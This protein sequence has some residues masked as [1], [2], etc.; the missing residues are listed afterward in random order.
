M[1]QNPSVRSILLTLASVAF[2]AL[3]TTPA[4]K[5]ES[6]TV[7]YGEFHPYSFTNAAGEAEGFAVDVV[8]NV[9]KSAG[10]EAEFVYSV[11]PA[12]TLEMLEAGEADLTTFL[13]TTPD[14][15]ERALA[16]RHIG[17]FELAA[18]TLRGSDASEN[19]DLAG[20]RV[21]VVKGS[22]A[23]TA[24]K[25]IPFVEIVEYQETDD[26]IVPLLVGEIDA[27]VSAKAAFTARL[28]RAK[29]SDLA[30][31]LSPSLVSM[32]YGLLVSNSRPDLV[33]VLDEALLNALPP[34]RVASLREKWFGRETYLYEKAGFWF[35]LVAAVFCGSIIG[36]MSWRIYQYR[37]EAARI[38]K[39]NKANDLLIRAL[40]EINGAIVIYNKDM[41]AIHRNAGFARAF[42]SL[43]H[44]VDSGATMSE[45]ISHSYQ[46]ELAT[47]ASD[48]KSIEEFVEE[49]VTAV[50]QGNDNW[51][52]VKAK[53]GL[54]YEARDFPLGDEYFASIRVDVTAQATLQD[55]I[56]QQAQ[57]LQHSNEQLETF[58]SIAAHDLRSPLSR[59]YPLVDFV[60]EDLSESGIRVPDQVGEYLD[61]IREETVLMKDL[62]DDLLLYASAGA[63]DGQR[64]L[65]DPVK[66]LER[67]LEVL[68]PPET[69][70]ITKPTA[71]PAVNVDPIAFEAVMRNLVGNAIKHH[72]NTNGTIEIT[73]TEDS[74]S[75]YIHV[76]DD[77]AG[78]PEEYQSVIFEPFQRLSTNN[79]GSGLGLAFIKKT[80]ESWGGHV[81]LS[82]SMGLGSQFTVSIP[83]EASGENRLAS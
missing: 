83:K 23:I 4:S 15:L 24:A 29:A 30:V 66:R 27:V 3:V 7:T 8:R 20:R 10:H 26:L 25:M 65:F 1:R 49:I 80:V 36:F 73:A 42:P 5:A 61:L 50:E 14:R 67:V 82:S 55:R 60:Q 6:L 2:S 16:T 58:A 28:R 78:I 47:L 12:R 51:R 68:G 71:M 40:D 74:G 45:L 31:P 37:R 22:A 62:V 54:V 56:R 77:G 38:L 72:G 69:F 76:T 11:N 46:T 18:F 33:S 70:V 53:N 64:Q 17:N 9:L 59:I 19:F 52:T 13:A 81:G 39:A 48:G 63:K 43:V 34:K 57:E 35:A 75:V 44:E 79:A 21:G 41:R 32:P